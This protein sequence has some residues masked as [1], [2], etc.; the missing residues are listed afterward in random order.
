MSDCFAG[1]MLSAAI[2]QRIVMKFHYKLGRT[3]TETYKLLKEVY[4]DECLSRARVFEWFKRFQAG[5]E[6]VEDDSRP[7]RPST[8]KTGDNIE[9]V[10]ALSRSDRRLSIR[11]IA[12][13][14]GIDKECVRQIL[15]NDFDTRTVCGQTVPNVLAFGQ[16]QAR[17][18]F[19]AD[20][21]SAIEN[22]PNLTARIITCDESRFEARTG[23]TK[24]EATMIVFFD[25]RGIVY[26]NWAPEGR[27]D[28]HY[29]LRVLGELRER[30]RERRPEFES[31]V[32]HQDDAPAHSALTVKTFLARHSIQ[33]LDHPADSPDLA[34]CD[35]Y[36][37]P[38][39]RSALRGTRLESVEAMK[40]RAERVLNELTE[41]DFRRCFAQWKIRMARCR[42]G[43]GA[44][45]E[46]IGRQS[47][48]LIATPRIRRIPPRLA[49]ISFVSRS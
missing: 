20:T 33:V 13:T 7:G 49:L 28:R 10:G 8:S 36:L 2:E 22:D 9:R 21:L 6:D 19:C 32:L 43:A 42:N 11:A 17:E 31:W 25:V 12:E 27:I 30:I 35:F 1:K 45:I 47:R 15:R 26:H 34:P 38:K 14:V 40:E 23:G 3:A 46:G 18:H 24:L 44:Y 39:V 16:R 41:E 5:R 4:G 48:Y 37:F 29:Y